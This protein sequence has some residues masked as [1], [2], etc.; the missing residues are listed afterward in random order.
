ML[1]PWLISCNGIW[2][3]VNV[4]LPS[5]EYEKSS[6]PSNAWVQ[7]TLWH[8]SP[9]AIEGSGLWALFEVNL[10]RI[11]DSATLTQIRLKIPGTHTILTQLKFGLNM[12]GCS[13]GTMHH[14]N[15]NGNKNSWDFLSLLS[16]GV[17]GVYLCF[18]VYMFLSQLVCINLIEVLLKCHEHVPYD[19][20]LFWII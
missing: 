1:F 4:Q 6:N 20:C 2:L 11:Y 13:F 8:W 9:Y 12:S 3:A 7:N 18:H 14:Q 15:R 17:Y 5:N 19:N 16:G 10:D